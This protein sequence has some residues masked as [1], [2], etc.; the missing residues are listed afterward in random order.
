MFSQLAKRLFRVLPADLFI[1]H[2]HYIKNKDQRFWAGTKTWRSE[3]LFLTIYFGNSQIY[4]F[5]AAFSVCA[6]SCKQCS[7]TEFGICNIWLIRT[8]KESSY[9]EVFSWKPKLRWLQSTELSAIT[10][11]CLLGS[12]LLSTLNVKLVVINE[13]KYY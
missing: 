1:D 5:H 3:R 9:R 12:F 11:I 13:V 6:F 10:V 4:R 8:A 7:S 2:A